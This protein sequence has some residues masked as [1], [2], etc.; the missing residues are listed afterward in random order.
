MKE[1]V[2][3]CFYRNVDGTPILCLMKGEILYML[4]FIKGGVCREAGQESVTGI[5]NGFDKKS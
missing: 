2:S 1:Q 4:S 5:L 3:P